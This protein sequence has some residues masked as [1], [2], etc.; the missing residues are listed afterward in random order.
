[1]SSFYAGVLGL[2]Q[3]GQFFLWSAVTC[4]RFYFEV[5]SGDKIE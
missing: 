5:K 3:I 1:M 2:K 4:H